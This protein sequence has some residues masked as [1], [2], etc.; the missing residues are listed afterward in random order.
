[1]DDDVNEEL[2]ILARSLESI[3]NFLNFLNK[4]Q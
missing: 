2:L 4:V 3:N 1:M